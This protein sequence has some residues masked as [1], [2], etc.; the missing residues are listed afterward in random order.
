MS[1]VVRGVK[2][3]SSTTCRT[4]HP[5]AGPGARNRPSLKRP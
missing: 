1:A 3:P 4:E 2:A 5:V